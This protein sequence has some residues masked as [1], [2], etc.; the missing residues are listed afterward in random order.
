MAIQ[1]DRQRKIKEKV[2]GRKGTK[3]RAG[4]IDGAYTIPSLSLALFELYL[5]SNI[6]RN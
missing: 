1:M 2:Y 3:P 4:D 5:C 6:G